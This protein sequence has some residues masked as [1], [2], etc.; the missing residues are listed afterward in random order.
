MLGSSLVKE[1]ILA[2]HYMMET[3]EFPEVDLFHYFIIGNDIL[4]PWKKRASFRADY[5]SP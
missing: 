4:Y 2:L 1:D 3:I 5:E